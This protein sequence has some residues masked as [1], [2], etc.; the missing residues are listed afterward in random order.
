MA[1][2]H[3]GA[4]TNFGCRQ[5]LV[6][7]EL[8]IHARISRHS[9]SDCGSVPQRVLIVSPS[10]PP[11]NT[12]DLHRVRISLPYYREYGWEPTILCVSA[13][14]CEGRDDPD[15]AAS[16]PRD[17]PIVAARAWD[18]RRCRRLGF[19]HLGYRSLI[20]LYRAGY[21]I[22]ATERYQVVF[23]ST[24]VFLSF[25]LGPLW[26]RRF[27]CKIVYDFQDPWYH[28]ALPYT[29]ATVPGKWWKYRVDQI[30][31]RFLERLALRAADHIIAV[32]QAYKHALSRR[33]Q[34]LSEADF[35]ILPF[36]A[37]DDDY[38]YAKHRQIKWRGFDR[39]S[40]GAHWFYVGA[41]N[42]SMAPIV[43]ALFALLSSYRNANPVVWQDIHLH[44]IGTSYAPPGRTQKLIEPLAHAAGIGDLVTE[45]PD[46]IPYFESIS[47]Y[48]DSDAILLIGSVDADY[49]ASKLLTAVL[50]KRP[51]LALF[52]QRSLVSRLAGRF[53][54]V[55][56]ASF[57]ATPDEPGFGAQIERGLAWL[58]A[59]DFDTA[60][61]ER[62][63]EPWSAKESTSVQCAIFDRVIGRGEKAGS[64][65]TSSPL[66]RLQ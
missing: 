55:F 28:E 46:R 63:L 59:P 50:S 30:L 18:L 4:E 10:F 42:H 34:R 65:K 26:K 3:D 61:I 17:I 41:C 21:K 22:L 8:V 52:H 48:A 58:R 2:T 54:N 66:L 31:A 40:A 15:L 56:L 57:A 37:T 14:S 13:E 25:V 45:Y 24:T 53:P 35:T 19:G 43:S 51:I 9:V 60:A 6:I 27:G 7:F 62:A 38:K 12:P 64:K 20:P 11:K 44:F 29:P 16:I 5:G 1:S 39:I 36:A 49:T 32:S 47:T 23:F 33:N